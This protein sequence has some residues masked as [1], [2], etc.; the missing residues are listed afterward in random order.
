MVE[1]VTTQEK[2]KFSQ[3]ALAS[4]C[5]NEK[6]IV[7]EEVKEFLLHTREK[8]PRVVSLGRPRHKKQ[9]RDNAMKTLEKRLN[10]RAK[11]R[12]NK[13]KA[14]AQVNTPATLTRVESE[15]GLRKARMLLNSIQQ[16][17]AS[18]GATSPQ[19]AST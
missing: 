2:L 14:K 10:Q 13:E 1:R 3:M 7:E 16:L 19:P 18:Q 17:M 11:G 12:E 15:E 5:I 8:K 4:L 9:P 6:R